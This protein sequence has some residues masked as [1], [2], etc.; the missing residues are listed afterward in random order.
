MYTDDRNV[1]H[2][3]IMRLMERDGISGLEVMR[4][5]RPDMTDKERARCF[6][7]CALNLNYCGDRPNDDIRNYGILCETF[8]WDIEAVMA[9]WKCEM[10]ASEIHPLIEYY[11]YKDVNSPGENHGERISAADDACNNRRCHPAHTV[12]DAADIRLQDKR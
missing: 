12:G 2:L 10:M 8:G 11:Y 9:E 1:I 4:V 7:C 3:R 5:M 6:E